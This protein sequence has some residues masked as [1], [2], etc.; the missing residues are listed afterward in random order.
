MNFLFLSFFTIFC[1]QFQG[2][3]PVSF[4]EEY[5]EFRLRESVFTVNGNYIFVN[6]TANAISKEISYPF[7]VNLSD[8]DSIHIFDNVRGQYLDFKKIPQAVIFRLRMIPHDTVRLNIFYE[9]KGVKDTVKYILVTTRNWGEPLRK[10][11]YTFETGQ[12]RKIK[13][14]SYT[15]DKTT[16]HN[17]L[18]KYFWHRENFFP[19]KDFLVILG[20]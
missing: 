7:P 18:Q 15:P 3:P 1:L 6:N 20:K 2:K 13:S 17:H 19:D 14:F 4:S 11:E 8:I 5:L 9:Q 16:I 10:A 12:S